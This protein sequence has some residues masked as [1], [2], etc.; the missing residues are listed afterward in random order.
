MKAFQKIISFFLFISLFFANEDQLLNLR[1]KAIQNQINNEKK[2]INSL[3]NPPLTPIDNF[4]ET[5]PIQQEAIKKQVDKNEKSEKSLTYFGYDIFN[6]GLSGS[7]WNNQP[8]P[9]DLLLGPG[10]ELIIE[11]WGET[12]IRT[13]HSI[14]RYGKINIDKIGQV[15]L[16]GI[17]LQQAKEKLLSRFEEVYSS[18]KGYSPAATLD[19]SLGKLKSINI[20]LLGEVEFPGIHTVHSF[21]TIFTGLMQTGGIPLSGS[22][23][24]IQLRRNGKTSDTFDFYSF[25]LEGN[26]HNDVRLMDGD[27]LFIPVRYSTIQIDGEINRK[28]MY[29]L[30]PGESL[31]QLIN[32]A[33]G[34]Q[35]NA[36]E[37]KIK[38]YRTRETD[39]S[40]KISID[41]TTY[42]NVNKNPQFALADGDKVFV[43]SRA[44]SLHEVYIY[45]QVKS[46]GKYS[47]NTSQGMTLKE[48]IDLSGGLNDTTYLKTVYLD[49]GE[50]IRSNIH[51]DFPEIIPFDLKLLIHGDSHENKNLQNWDIVLIRKNPNF[52]PP[53]KVWL[54]GEVNVPGVYTIQKKGETL[55]DILQRAHGFTPNAFK[56]G[57][58]LYRNQELVV[59][60]NNNIL[61]MDGDSLVV[62]LHPGVVKVTGEVYKPGLIQFDQNK[63]IYDFIEDAGGFTHDADRKQI[64]VVYASGD[65]EIKKKFNRVQI[66]EGSTIII[67]EKV[68]TEPFNLTE[69]ASNMASIVSSFA[70]IYLLLSQ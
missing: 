53:K 55:Q 26:T 61:V 37:S 32:F 54:K 1:L 23:R 58:R 45:G 62:P 15:H 8:P 41:N 68:D 28:G 51:S 49:R 70:T 12:Q 33:A 60:Q 21:S 48:L 19:V 10:D 40:S 42:I 14:D 38:V 17:T 44:S 24:N 27:I 29:E 2:N 20:T 59:S 35:P 52:L 7:I 6:A 50:I 5:L 36:M 66:H 46:P 67:Q 9:S 69:Y 22:L 65:V 25:L 56:D 4:E 43:H 63:S 39:N 64:M 16:T 57:I 31:S 47:F 30:L 34:L 13:V 18:L 3:Q 11:I